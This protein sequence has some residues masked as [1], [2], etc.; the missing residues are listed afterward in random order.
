LK[1][2]IEQAVCPKNPNELGYD[3]IKTNRKV[4]C[5]KNLSMFYHRL[6]RNSSCF[7]QNPHNGATYYIGKGFEDLLKKYFNVTLAP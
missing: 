3:F 2:L 7:F 5:F 6:K 1:A 4:N